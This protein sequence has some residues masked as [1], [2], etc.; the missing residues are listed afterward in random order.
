MA[1]IAAGLVR[2]R[3]P[4]LLSTPK[5]RRLMAPSLRSGSAGLNWMP[6]LFNTPRE[7]VTITASPAVQVHMMMHHATT[8]P[9]API[10]GNVAS[11]P[12][13]VV[14]FEHL[15]MS[16]GEAVA[17]V[18]MST[19]VDVTAASWVFA[20]SK[21][22]SGAASSTCDPVASIPADSRPSFFFLPRFFG[23]GGGR[24]TSIVAHRTYQAQLQS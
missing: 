17:R 8:D 22:A 19:S 11:T 15:G 2:I 14:A 12:A 9:G 18:V 1:L 23:G 6:P 3:D 20:F 4:T 7:D 16:Q 21:A 5:P 13:P 24:A 10:M